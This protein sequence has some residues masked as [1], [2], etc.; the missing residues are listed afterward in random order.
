MKLTKS[1][2]ILYTY[3]FYQPIETNENTFQ[4]PNPLLLD[5]RK[6]Y[7]TYMITILGLSEK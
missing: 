1:M 5:Y 4:M 7:C 3:H 6:L 2:S